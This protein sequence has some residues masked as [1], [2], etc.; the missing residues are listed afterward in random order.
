MNN[1]LLY[2]E[3]LKSKQE[4][5]MT[6]EFA[7]ILFDMTTDVSKTK[8]VTRWGIDSEEVIAHAMAIL[9]R[10]WSQ[11]SVD[12]LKKSGEKEENFP[13][14]LYTFYYQTMI[15]APIQLYCR[16]K[17]ERDI[18]RDLKSNE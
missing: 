6:D 1:K 10:S 12:F 17:R 13:N 11:F 8:T 2:Q 16:E 14:R 7:K 4:E 18:K 5:K 15:S 9:A 3:F